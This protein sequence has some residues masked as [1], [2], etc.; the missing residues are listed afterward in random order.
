M[1]YNN[2]FEKLFIF[3]MANNH[4]GDVGHGL[5]IINE[6]H[7]VSKDFDFRYAIK[8]QYRNLDTFIHPDYKNSYEFKYI[9]RFSETQLSNEE[10]LR[11][12]DTARQLGFVLICTPFDESSVDKVVNYD[13]DI[14]KIA[15]CSF[16][17]W[18]LLEKIARTEKPIIVSTAGATG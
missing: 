8:F 9:K 6:M 3:E 5:E 15:S 11:M 7:Q 4:M 16:T 13:F 14:I 2:F 17:D 10:L 1:K 18:P 12:R